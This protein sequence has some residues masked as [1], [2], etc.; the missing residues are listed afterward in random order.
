MA[1]Y[2]RRPPR[3]EYDREGRRLP[4]R[5]DPMDGSRGGRDPRR[6]RED[7]YGGGG[8]RDYDD[9][10][11]RDPR[12]R[13]DDRRRYDDDRGGL[14]DGRDDRYGGGRRREEDFG[15]GRDR[16]RRDDRGR[17]R[18]K[19]DTPEKRSPTPP[20][21][22]P[23]TQRRRKASGWDVHAPGYEAYTAMQAK[24]TG[25]FNLPGANRQ[26][27]VA[28]NI[29][30]PVGAAPDS[31][32]M[33]AAPMPITAV[34]TGNLEQQARRLYIAGITPDT[35]EENLTAFLK[36][37]LPELGIKIDGDDA[38]LQEVKVNHEKNYA[39]IDFSNPEDATKTMELDGTVFLGQPLKVRRPKDY[40]SATDLAVVFGGIVPGVVST[41][42]PDSINKIFVGGLP[43]Y[44]N[45]AQV[46][47]LLQTFGELRAFNLVKDG[48]TGL[49]KG[50]AFFE[51]MD[52]GVTDVA[53]Q[54]LNGME[55]GD[56]YLVVQ[57][58]S[59]GANPNKPN[60]PNMPGMMPPPRPAILP[61][62]STNPPSPILLL[63]NMVTPEE[64]IQ[65]NDYEDIFE[66]IKE[67]MGRYGQVVNLKIPR[68]QK[69]SWV[70]S[71][72]SEPVK[73]DVELGVGRVYVKFA[74]TDS[75]SAALNA[76]AGRQ[77]SGRSIIATYV[78]EDPFD[79]T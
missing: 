28:I 51:Y 35:T 18:D 69:K 14:R 10:R 16:G 5:D 62:D 76:V 56:R 17:G 29:P 49:S 6:E 26:H 25:Y 75:A 73:S 42:V 23:L 40:L 43:T 57:R 12:R 72:T 45:E 30:A 19:V 31:Y 33:I 32:G 21:A 9:G 47:E 8:R 24:A 38:G 50:F 1:D 15:G 64:L 55:L 41:N 59:I 61:V 48:T 71:S 67:E 78:Q 37:T 20:G 3:P 52:P 60:M 46:M 66:D 44:L 65:D 68:P 79:E 70:P 13:D 11:N 2:D 34:S 22:V 63:L 74:A 39:Y 27:T 7:R 58:A 53:C 54:G 4:P 36:S 77:F